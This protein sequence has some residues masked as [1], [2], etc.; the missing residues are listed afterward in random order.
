MR[1]L[2]GPAARAVSA[3]ALA[4]EAAMTMTG[5]RYSYSLFIIG[6]FLLL[7]QFGSPSVQDFSLSDDVYTL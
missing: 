7:S 6:R 4:S 2:A 1:H 5:G 3:V